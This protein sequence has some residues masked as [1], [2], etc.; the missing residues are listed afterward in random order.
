MSAATEGLPF[1]QYISSKVVEAAPMSKHRA[2]LL[3]G[4]PV[5]DADPDESGFL[6]QYPDEG[7]ANVKGFAGYISWCPRDVF[8]AHNNPTSYMRFGQALEALM[9]GHRIARSFWSSFGAFLFCSEDTGAIRISY[10]A[11]N[12]P[13]LNTGDARERSE[14]VNIS[15]A[16]DSQNTFG[17]LTH[18]LWKPSQDDLLARDWKVL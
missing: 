9:L 10:Y 12:F 7:R 18:S 11:G 15:K 14:T 2:F 3:L 6:V 8:L 5:N 4:R 1:S 17:D 13:Y 16:F